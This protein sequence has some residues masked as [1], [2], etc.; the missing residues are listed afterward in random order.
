[1]FRA[2]YVWL[3]IV[4]V[5]RCLTLYITAEEEQFTIVTNIVHRWERPA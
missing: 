2:D 4:F 5:K 1:M 3:E